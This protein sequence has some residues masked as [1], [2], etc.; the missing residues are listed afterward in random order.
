VRNTLALGELVRFSDNGSGAP[1]RPPHP[2]GAQL[3]GLYQDDD[4]VQRFTSGLD[5]VLATAILTLDN[6]EAYVDPLLT[7]ADFV[8]WLAQWVG[9]DLA[10][11]SDER[12]RR[13]LILEAATLYGL[14]GT[15]EG[16]RRAIELR[17]GLRPEIE[18][19]GG[20][21]AGTDPGTPAPGQPGGTLVV[22][23]RGPEAKA[24]DLKA[25]DDFVA[26]IKPAHV[27]HYV[28]LVTE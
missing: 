23:I 6:L 27:I 13:Q 24:I 1:P 22:R 2:I 7:P 10:G 9:V 4:L 3:P 18:E 21:I 12:R 26:R 25:L 28:E 5:P 19:T 15:I 16:L 20:S 17:T 14:R 11:V 8:A